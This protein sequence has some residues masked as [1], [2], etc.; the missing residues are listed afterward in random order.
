MSLKPLH[1]VRKDHTLDWATAERDRTSCSKNE[2]SLTG[3]PK[4]PGGTDPKER[5][6]YAAPKNSP[7]KAYREEVGKNSENYSVFDA[8]EPNTYAVMLIAKGCRDSQ[9]GRRRFE[10]GFPFHN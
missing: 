3:S 2:R 9:A 7:E 10:P 1:L 4:V 8:P 6:A 5:L